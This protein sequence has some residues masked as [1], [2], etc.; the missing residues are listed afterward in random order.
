MSRPGQVRRRRGSSG[1]RSTS[2]ARAGPISPGRSRAASRSRTAWTSSPRAAAARGTPA[3]RLV[4]EPGEDV[5]DGRLAGLVAEEARQDAVLDDAAHALD[6][7]PVVRPARRWQMLVPMTATMRPGSVTATAGT[8]TWA[9]TLATATAVPGRRPVQAAASA[10]RL[11][12]P[13]AD[14]HDRRATSSRRRR[15]RTAGRARRS[16]PRP[17]SRPAFDQIA[18]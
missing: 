6:D 5:A 13:L 11:A 10:V 3:A 8:E 16:T 4:D 7:A 18:L 1:C 2:R 9:S 17:G 15:P 12:G 14:G